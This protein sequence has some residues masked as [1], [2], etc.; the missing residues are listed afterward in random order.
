MIN[1]WSASGQF[2]LRGDVSQ[3]LLARQGLWSE[4]VEP[5]LILLAEDEALIALDVQ[6]ALESAGF[7][8]LH[9]FGGDD[10][11]AALDEQAAKLVGIITD[12]KFG[13]A[14]DGWE[15]GRKARE[16]LPHVPVIYISGDSAHEHTSRGVPGSVMLQ[17]PF[18]PAQLVTAIAALLNAVPPPQPS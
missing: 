12:V 3:R 1:V 7:A 13:E 16:F 18:A 6:E 11:L 5:S 9:V 17:K 8:V 10:A 2:K 15:V 4:L 14:V